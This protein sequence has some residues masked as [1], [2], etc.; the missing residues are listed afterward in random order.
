ML[1]VLTFVS[2][3]LFVISLVA[4]SGTF[5]YERFIETSLDQKGIELG[6]AR[7]AINPEL[8]TEFKALDEKLRTAKELL[9]RHT[10][11]TLFFDFLESS[12]L[13][14]VQYNDFSYLLDFSGNITINMK[15]I[16]QSFNSVTLQSDIFKDSGIMLDS[17]FS[18]LDLDESGNVE[19]TITSKIDPSF[20]LYRNAFNANED[21]ESF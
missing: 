17:K 20:I 21:L 16:A 18:N 15:G 2:S 12:T 4:A 19:F 7:Q 1:N 9:N 5:V 11:L 3:V 14:N 8:I 6:K 10:A 13:Q